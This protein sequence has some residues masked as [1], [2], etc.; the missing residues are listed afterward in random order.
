VPGLISRHRS[1]KDRCM[2][3]FEIAGA[4]FVL[5]FLAAVMTEIEGNEHR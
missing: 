2:L 3:I 1:Y 5:L 4:G